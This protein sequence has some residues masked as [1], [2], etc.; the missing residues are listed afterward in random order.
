[1]PRPGQ[2]LFRTVRA[3]REALLLLVI[4]YARVPE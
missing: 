4:S 1:M 2:T 3:L